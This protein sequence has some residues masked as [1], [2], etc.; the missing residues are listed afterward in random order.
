[1]NKE[2]WSIEEIAAD[3][4]E[5]I[6][7]ELSCDWQEV[8]Y[9]IDIEDTHLYR[10]AVGAFEKILKIAECGSTDKK[11]RNELRDK[12]QLLRDENDYIST[13]AIIE[14]VNE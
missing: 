14:L 7:T 11:S 12:I 2:K 1:M 5:E 10:Y 3:A 6:R 13:K 8:G 9:T 4:L